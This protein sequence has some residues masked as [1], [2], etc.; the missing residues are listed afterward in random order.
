MD[1]IGK[2]K[3]RDSRGRMGSVIYPGFIISK[4]Y[5]LG[6]VRSIK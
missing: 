2:I 5:T 6:N 1:S 3:Q 4:F